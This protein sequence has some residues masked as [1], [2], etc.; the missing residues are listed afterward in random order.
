MQLRKMLI[1]TEKKKLSQQKQQQRQE[2]KKRI[3]LIAE[4]IQ[5]RRHT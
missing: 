3:S 1:H 4:R 5:W 2:K